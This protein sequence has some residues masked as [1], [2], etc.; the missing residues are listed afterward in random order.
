MKTTEIVES[1]VK[2]RISH[3]EGDYP[4]PEIKERLYYGLSKYGFSENKER[5]KRDFYGNSSYIFLNY[6]F[7]KH[8][9]FLGNCKCYLSNYEEYDGS[10][11]ISF[12]I[13]IMG[14]ITNYGSIRE[15][16]DY[17]VND[18]ES[19]Y[20]D[21]LGNDFTINSNHNTRYLSEDQGNQTNSITSYSDNRNVIRGIM[22]N[23][24]LI[25]IC[26]V[27]T[28]L[29]MIIVIERSSNNYDKEENISTQ[30]IDMIIERKID[31]ILK[32]KEIEKLIRDHLSILLQNKKDSLINRMIK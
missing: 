28:L 22:I 27:C 29:I 7:N 32:E 20:N 17:F 12:T 8:F 11:I 24:L 13:V 15:T 10:L 26:A 9:K 16:I 1:K 21:V 18:L 4:F 14:A 23:R 2:V 31:K 19:V 6:V 25:G 3:I 5:N 30:N